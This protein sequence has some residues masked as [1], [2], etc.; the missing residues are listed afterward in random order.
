MLPVSDFDCLESA[1]NALILG[2]PWFRQFV[3]F[4][5]LRHHEV[6]DK[7]NNDLPSGNMIGIGIRRPGYSLTPPDSSMSLSTNGAMALA[8]SPSAHKALHVQKLSLQRID[9]NVGHPRAKLIG[10]NKVGLKAQSMVTYNVKIT[11]GSPEQQLTVIFDTG[12]FMCA[13]FSDLSPRGMKELG[14]LSVNQYFGHSSNTTLTALLLAFACAVF[15][16]A[17]VVHLKGKRGTRRDTRL[18]AVDVM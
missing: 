9:V 7:T 6:T 17:L 14:L 16:V 4:H 5:D 13:V 10:V 3:I 8:S 1:D 2:D 12:S 15:V 18:V 11:V